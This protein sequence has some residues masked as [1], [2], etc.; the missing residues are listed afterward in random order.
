MRYDGLR[1]IPLGGLGEIG[2]NMMVLEYRDDL[3]VIDAGLM[4][5]EDYMLGI[6]MV[7]PDITYLR[8]HIDKVRAIILTHGHEDHI[9]ALPFILKELKVPVYGTPFTLALVAEKLQEHEGIGKVNFKRVRPRDQVEIG[10]FQV[11]FI[12][13]CHSIVDGTGL[14][15][16]TP[17]GVV[18]HTGDF[19]ID[20]APAGGE[21]T[22]L[23]KFAEYGERGVLVLLSDSTNAEREGY[24]LSEREIGQRLEEIIRVSPGRVIVALFASNIQRM[25]EVMDTAVKYGRKVAFVG[26]NVVINTRIARELGYMHF[27]PGGVIDIKKLDHYAPENV[28]VFT[29]GSQGE[30]LSA[31]SLIAT[32]NHKDIQIQKGDTVV[33]SSRFIPGNEKAITHMINHLCRRGANV[34]YEK[35]SAIH[36]SG[37]GYREELRMMLNLIRP[38]FFIP[39]HGEYRHLVQHIQLAREVGMAEEK[40]LLAE[41]GDVIVFKSGTGKIVDRIEVGKVFVDGKSV[42]DVEDVVLRDRKQLSED[43]MVIP[44]MVINERTGE[45]VSGP[46]I[47]SRGVFFEE[48]MGGILEQAKEVIK[49]VLE[50]FSIESKA[51]DLAVE[52]EVRRALKRFFRKE[53]N[54]RPVIIPVIIEM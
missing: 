46:D 32:N 9:G 45:V 4:F 53:V 36:V 6:D 31:L 52:N 17:V 50:G 51:D 7:I 1:L 2:L 20:Q 41:D 54:R 27:P 29:T 34:I 30:P 35:I 23:R 28:L 47:I 3:I 25:Q 8:R 14:A 33:L 5:P 24:T 48:K 49:D 40:L 10:P 44:V 43:G 39:I 21:L 11:E 19:K 12:R 15:I 37:H 16:T 22:D 26:R 38:E 18:I 13:T 42:G